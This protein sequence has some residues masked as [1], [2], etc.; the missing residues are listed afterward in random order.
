MLFYMDVER[1]HVSGE[2][3]KVTRVWKQQSLDK[4]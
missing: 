4:F 3:I 2:E 1:G